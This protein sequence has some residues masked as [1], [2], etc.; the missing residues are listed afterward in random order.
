MAS[1]PNS[2]AIPAPYES[3][4][5]EKPLTYNE[6]WALFWTLESSMKG[7]FPEESGPSEILR[8]ER[9]AWGD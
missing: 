6:G 9:E 5:D 1:Q 4:L 3:E 2:P 7:W 8:R